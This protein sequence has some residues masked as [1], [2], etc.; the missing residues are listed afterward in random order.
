MINCK[1]EDLLYHNCRN[2]FNL[3]AHQLIMSQVTTDN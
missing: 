2:E 1:S 3:I